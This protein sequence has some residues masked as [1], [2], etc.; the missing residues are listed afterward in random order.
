M[1][2][3]TSLDENIEPGLPACEICKGSAVTRV[4]V[5]S[6][7]PQ[8]VRR[9]IFGKQR[10]SHDKEALVALC[11]V[12]TLLHCEETFEG[13]GPVRLLPSELMIGRAFPEGSESS[14]R[15]YDYAAALLRV[16]E[17]SGYH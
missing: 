11:S 7:K 3:L 12:C 14:G 5:S 17:R 4:P 16:L 15:A 10:E 9:Y 1:D 13:D 2:F 8:T 6:L